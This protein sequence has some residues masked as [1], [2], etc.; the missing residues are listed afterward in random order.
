MLAAE[1]TQEFDQ[2]MDQ[3]LMDE[4]MQDDYEEENDYE[5]QNG[6]LNQ[7]EEEYA[8]F[9]EKLNARSRQEKAALKRS[10]RETI[11]DLRENMDDLVKQDAHLLLEKMECVNALFGQVQSTEDA[12]LDSVAINLIADIS[13]KKTR[14]LK[15]N[16]SVF[17]VSVFVSKLNGWL[18]K[19]NYEQNTQISGN[20]MQLSHGEDGQGRNWLGLQKLVNR[21]SKRAPSIDFML[22]PLSIEVKPKE[23]KKRAQHEANTSATVKPI[24]VNFRL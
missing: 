21:A 9:T 5:D 3:E 7:E 24:E 16:A 11:Q 20:F 1:I 2:E 22:G 23:K 15:M 17:D 18:T 4:E 8:H 6:E 13:L 14:A 12:A 19:E 10:Y